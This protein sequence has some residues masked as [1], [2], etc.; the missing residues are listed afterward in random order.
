MSLSASNRR[1]DAR[2]T[3]VPISQY[4]KRNP[5]LP[6]TLNKASNVHKGDTVSKSSNA[7]FVYSRTAPPEVMHLNVTGMLSQATSI[8][9]DTEMAMNSVERMMEYLDYASE[10]PAILPDNRFCPPS[11][12]T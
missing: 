5:A 12:V 6:S 1:H 10:A 4:N 7:V 11:S 9:N 2:H 3:Q 8:G